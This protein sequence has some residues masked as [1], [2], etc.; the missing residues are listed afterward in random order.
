ME[1][2][3]R[4][5]SQ[6][7]FWLAR[8]LQG[9]KNIKYTYNVHSPWT[10]RYSLYSWVQIIPTK[11]TRYATE[12]VIACAVCYLIGGKK[13]EVFGRALSPLSSTWLYLI[14]FSM[15]FSKYFSGIPCFLVSCT[16]FS[17]VPVKGVSLSASSLLTLSAAFFQR[18]SATVNH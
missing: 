6:I 8:W 1:M 3:K 17:A 16:S 4:N 18:F 14:D 2:R 12:P 11:Y 5:G 15:W 10:D 9:K 13:R 7:L